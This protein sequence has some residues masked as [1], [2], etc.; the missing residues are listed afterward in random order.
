MKR[1]FRINNLVAFGL[2]VLVTL[3]ILYTGSLFS[4]MVGTVLSRPVVPLDWVKARCFEYQASGR[5]PNWPSVGIGRWYFQEVKFGA[6]EFKI[7]NGED[8]LLVFAPDGDGPHAYILT[9]EGELLQSRDDAV[10]VGCDWR[11]ISSPEREAPRIVG[12]GAFEPVR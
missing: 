4:L 10:S 8:W 9:R 11:T 12:T 3:A 6:R 2:G 5:E 1:I 7:D